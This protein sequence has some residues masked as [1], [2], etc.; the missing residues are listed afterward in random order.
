MKRKDLSIALRI[1]NADD[2]ISLKMLVDDC[3]TKISE[4]LDV[5]E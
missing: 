1:L 5:T 4:V 3:V 2:Y